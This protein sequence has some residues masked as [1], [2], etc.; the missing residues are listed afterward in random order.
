MEMQKINVSFGKSILSGESN[1]QF[2]SGVE[3]L[4]TSPSLTTAEKFQKFI[5]YLFTFGATLV[6]DLIDLY[7]EKNDLDELVNFRSRLCDNIHERLGGKSLEELRVD[8]TYIFPVRIK[9]EEVNFYL[10]QET[11]AS[12]TTITYGIEG[13]MMHTVEKDLVQL[14][15][16]MA[17]EKQDLH[18]DARTFDHFK[19]GYQKEVGNLNLVKNTPAQELLN[20]MSIDS[21]NAEVKSLR[22]FCNGL[23]FQQAQHV[24]FNRDFTHVPGS[25]QLAPDEEINKRILNTN[26]SAIRLN[27]KRE[28]IGPRDQ[29]C[30]FQ[31]TAIV[32]EI[33]GS[34]V[35]SEV[36]LF[37]VPAPAL[38]DQG[39]IPRFDDKAQLN[40]KS[41]ARP[42]METYVDTSTFPP[43]FNSVN[44]EIAHE[45]L[46]DLIVQGARHCGASRVVL[47]AFG[48]GAFLG[49]LDTI[50][51]RCETNFSDEAK[52]IAAASLARTIVALRAA[53]KEVVFSDANF[54]NGFKSQ[55]YWEKVNEQ[56]GK[57]PP[58][59][60]VNGNQSAIAAGWIQE[61]D[62]IVNAW[63]PD[64]LVGNGL[65]KDASFDGYVGRNS[66]CH[67][68]HAAACADYNAKNPPR[69]V[70]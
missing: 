42:E 55:D 31:K 64:S 40:M 49:A 32:E 2:R 60:P 70:I 59:Q 19:K 6:V 4:T 44:Y 12:A 15:R 28:D 35:K 69:P 8:K 54:E 7:S 43:K 34:P 57:E 56:L 33:N 27:N 45:N 16:N 66:S 22:V 29:V 52:D 46:G 65:G 39:I 18:L 53:G 68:A 14:V 26:G 9:G 21:L 3:D 25:N 17:L 67:A 24:A 5:S 63:D 1:A 23:S 13:H 41:A 30:I 36:F 47:S 61:G 58:V 37:S 11:K 38:D 20:E 62:M 50:D 51:T 10:I 48:V